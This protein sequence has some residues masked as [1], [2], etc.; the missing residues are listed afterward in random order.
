MTEEDQE[1][2]EVKEGTVTK[3]KRVVAFPSARRDIL[4]YL[5]RHAGRDVY[6]SEIA[7]VLRMPLPNVQTAIQRLRQGKEP[8]A[9]IL[10]GQVFRY[11]DA[12]ADTVDLQ[13][14]ILEVLRRR[15]GVEVTVEELTAEL[16]ETPEAIRNAIARLRT[17]KK[18]PI[19]IV[20]SKQS[21]TYPRWA[22]SDSVGE[23]TQALLATDGASRTSGDVVPF[24]L[25]GVVE[26][27]RRTFVEVGPTRDGWLV[28]QAEDGALF[29][30][31]PL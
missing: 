29:K 20:R 3:R 31:E 17:R 14:R 9:V 4:R 2:K 13:A 5:K 11:G 6:A 12:V 10:R 26:L 1:P 28:I 22:V 23:R 16:D 30:A 7:N 27:A 15:A 8:I 21:W 19:E 25:T 24:P 18:E